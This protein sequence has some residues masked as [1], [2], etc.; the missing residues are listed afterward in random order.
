MTRSREAWER[1]REMNIPHDFTFGPINSESLLNDP[2]HLAFTLSRYKFAVKMMRKCKHVI[3]IGCGEGVGALM[4]L[5]ETA[6][7]VTAIDFDESQIG[8]ASEYILPHTENRLTFMCQDLVSS[9]YVGGL[10]DGLVSIDVIEHVIPSEEDQFFRN[11]VA[12]LEPRAIAVFGTPNG[13][14]HQ[15]ASARSQ[16]GH[17][18]LFEPER[19]TSTL[20]RY[21][22]HVFLFSMN[23][24]MVHTGYDKL[25]HYLLALC[26]T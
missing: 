17:I 3:E 22:G 25:A 15:Y 13:C 19:L 16:E 11:C 14:A 6:A 18:N 9:T 8:Y 20:E 21:F 5:A 4:F 12:C 2:K 26:V 7:T 1:V 24:E 10:G 23:D